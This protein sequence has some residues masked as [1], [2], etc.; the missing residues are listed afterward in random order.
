MSMLHVETLL[1]FIR[2]HVFGG[3]FIPHFTLFARA[4]A[5]LPVEA[6]AVWP[7]EHRAGCPGWPSRGL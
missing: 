4:G 7:L 3:L 6:A 2:S 1:D 5:Q